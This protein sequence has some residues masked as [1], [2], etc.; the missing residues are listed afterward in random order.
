MNITDSLVERKKNSKANSDLLGRMQTDE[1]A[2]K[3]VFFL[4]FL[5]MHPQ[6]MDVPRLWVKME[7]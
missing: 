1:S 4:V 5:G 3:N 2:V 6:H 7:L